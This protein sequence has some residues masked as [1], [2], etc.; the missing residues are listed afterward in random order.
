MRKIIFILISIVS[1]HVWVQAATIVQI[2]DPETWAYTQLKQYIGKTIQFDVPFYVTNNYNSSSLTISPRRIFTPTNQA[3]P[4][5]QEYNTLYSLNGQGTI[6]LTNVSGYHRINERLYNLTVKV[7]STSSVSLV[8]CDFVG[9]T[10]AE[11]EQGYDTEAVNMR[12][13]AS[14]IVC[15][16][17]LEYYLVEN[18]GTG[19]GPDNNSDHQKQRTKVSK[20]LATINADIFGQYPPLFLNIFVIA[21]QAVDTQYVEQISRL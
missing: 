15:T 17:N 13:E 5:S 9:N 7:N 18:L 12:G 21:T 11:L 20:A 14:I 3:L 16:M 8:S 4:L 19:Y 1:S 6:T 2:E 10:R